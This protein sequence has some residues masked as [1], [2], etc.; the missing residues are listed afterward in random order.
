MRDVFSRDTQ[1]AMGQ[2]AERGNY[3]HLY[4][5]GMYWGL[6]NTAERPEASYAA[7][8][9]GGNKTNF[10]VVKVEAGPYSI[11]ATDGNMTAWTT[12]YNLAKAGLSSNASYRRVQGL[13][14]DGT[15]N[16]AYPNLVDI[17]NLIDY[18]LVILYG[19]NLDA[20]ISEFLGNSS[21]NNFYAMRDRTGAS[22]GFHFFCHDSEHTL[23]PWRVD[24]DRTGP[25]SA[26]DSDL[27]KSNPQWVWQRLSANPEF[28][29]RVADHIHKHFFNGGVLTPESATALIM[30]RKNQIDRAVVGESARWGDAKLGAGAPYTRETWLAAVNNVLQN[31]L[32]V[33]TDIVLGQLKAK[34]LYPN[35]VAPSLNR[36]GGD[37]PPGFAVTISAPAGTIYFTLDGSDPRLFG[38]AVSASA[39]PLSGEIIIDESLTLKAR[40]LDGTN[41]SALVEA[42]FTLIQTFTDL[43]LTEI[44]YHP[45]D[46]GSFDGSDLEYIELKNIG[47]AELDLSGV[48]VTNGI[49]YR[50]PNGTRL[51]PGAFAVLVSDAAAFTNLHPGVS[52]AGVYTNNLA[53]TGDTIEVRHAVGTLITKVSFTDQAPWP[54][55]ADGGGFSLVPINPNLNTDANAPQNWRASSNVGGSPGADDPNP[56]LPLILVNEL[57]SHTDLPQVDT[58]ELFNPGSEAADIGGW[59]LTDDRKQPRKF[60]LPPG[61]LVPARGYLL[62]DESQFNTAASGTNAFTFSSHGDEVY[63]YSADALGEL[64]GYSDGFSFP[65][66]E[67]G[68][69]FGRYTNSVGE[70]QY[71]PQKTLTLGTSN[72]GPKIG[73]VIINEIRYQPAAGEDEFIELKN[74]TDSPINLYDPAAPT[75]HWRVEGLDFEF[76]ADAILPA[77]GLLVLT[78]S[79]PAGFRSRNSIPESVPVFGPYRGTLQDSGEL[80][81]ILRPDQAD[82]DTNGVVFIPYV[83][84]DAVRYNDKS[85]WP[86][87]AAGF[88]PSL[89]KISVGAYGNDAGNW[90]ASPGAASPGFEND[91]NRPP[92]V[93]TS[94]VQDIVSSTYP[95]TVNVA[96]TASDDGLPNPPG[97]LTYRWTQITGPGAVTFGSSIA[98]TSTVQLPGVGTYLLRLTVSDGEAE[99]HSD[100]SISISRPLGDL[101][102]VTAGAVW[103]YWDKGTDLGTAWTAPGFA[104]SAWLSGPAQLGYGDGDEATKVGFGPDANAKFWTTYFRHAMVIPPGT[105]IATATARLVRDDGAIVY[106]NGREVW[107]SN[108]PETLITFT[109]AASA[110][111]GGADESAWNEQGIDAST[112][113]P[114]TNVIAVEVHQS[115]GNSSDISFDFELVSQVVASNQPPSVAAGGDLTIALPSDGFLNG[116]VTDD[117]L[118]SIV[119]NL[120]SELDGPAPVDFQTPASLQ[121]YVRFSAPGRYTL[122]LSAYDGELIGFDDLIMTVEPEITYGDWLPNHFTASELLNPSVSGGTADPDGDGMD[123]RSEHLAGTDPRNSQSFLGLMAEPLEGA[124]FTIQVTV[125]AGRSYSMEFSESA[126][127]PWNVLTEL[128]PTQTSAVKVEDAANAQA[129]RY[130]RIVTPSQFH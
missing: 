38:G 31:F 55:A 29:L 95:F 12:L 77:H 87:N 94:P 34:S 7:T 122:R 66:A 47:T 99:A 119:T 92:K 53:N 91:G 97:G 44:M 72:S 11:N 116:F 68:V 42:P 2:N 50:F 101:K 130:Y 33:R 71:P 13:N 84:V 27:F 93:Q 41:W 37:V 107:R 19:G 114:G 65:A 100:L 57:L 56:N 125:V 36:F 20:P 22:G 5:N 28:R 40:A 112:L 75:N 103:K 121:T 24:V 85:P 59:Y 21:P 128:R 90:R 120:W 17:D 58:V 61:S 124:A 127:G 45:P 69:S 23:L 89:E 129:T 118:V 110:T 83:Q 123:N 4:I 46:T 98:P 32:P 81:R 54:V 102:L 79:D 30:K 78:S 1:L 96:G 63:L 6:Y 74:L 3:Y 109:T 43:A 10:D 51:S 104:D 126:T 25:F 106:I 49:Y 64:T 113:H 82:I 26:G 108:M 8:Y 70:I 62:F 73:S 60:K 117:G 14:P 15:P 111:I 39:R 115:V 9:F 80:I 18:M 52:I 35:T 76:P 16:P 86:T 88:G 48:I 105:Q 67:N